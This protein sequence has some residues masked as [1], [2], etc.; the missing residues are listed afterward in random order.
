MPRPPGD[1]G[2]SLWALPAA[3]YTEVE[4]VMSP[5]PPKPHRR[6]A[7][8]REPRANPEGPGPP[9]QIPS[10]TPHGTRIPEAPPGL[11]PEGST[12][13]GP[14]ASGPTQRQHSYQMRA[15]DPEVRPTRRPNSSAPQGSR[16]QGP[17][18][19]A[20]APSRTHPTA[21]HSTK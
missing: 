15:S 8:W 11:P 1:A 14:R 16:T 6:P 4:P 5:R 17:P 13:Q 9:K 18:Q 10:G 21:P 7:P 12:P 20:P 2:A 3:N 19:P